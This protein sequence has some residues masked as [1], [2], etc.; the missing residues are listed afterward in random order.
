MRQKR[1]KQNRFL[2]NHKI[3]KPPLPLPYQAWAREQYPE[4]SAEE[5]SSLMAKEETK[6]AYADYFLAGE[7]TFLGDWSLGMIQKENGS[8]HPFSTPLPFHEAG[9]DSWYQYESFFSNRS[10]AE[11][12]LWEYLRGEKPSIWGREQM[13]VSSQPESNGVDFSKDYGAC[14][15]FTYTVPPSEAGWISPYIRP[16]EQTEIHKS[17]KIVILHNDKPIWPVGAVLSDSDTWMKGF[18]CKQSLYVSMEG[19]SLRVK[20]GD[21]IHFV[22]EGECKQRNLLDPVV[23]VHHRGAP[24]QLPSPQKDLVSRDGAAIP[25]MPDTLI[26]LWQYRVWIADEEVEGSLVGWM[27]DCKEIEAPVWRRYCRAPSKAGV[28]QL[29]ARW[30]DQVIPVRLA[31]CDQNGEYP[32]AVLPHRADAHWDI[33]EATAMRADIQALLGEGLSYWRD[34]LCMVAGEV[35]RHRRSSNDI[36]EFFFVSDTHHEINHQRSIPVANCLSDVLG[37]DRLIFGGD[38]M[39]GQDVLADSFAVRDAWLSL[40]DTFHGFWY[41]ARG[42]HDINTAFTPFSMDDFWTDADYHRYILQKSGV[43]SVQSGMRVVRSVCPGMQDKHGGAVTEPTE[44]CLF[45]YVDDEKARIRYYFLDDGCF[46]LLDEVGGRYDTSTHPRVNVIPYKEQLKWLQYTAT[47]G[48]D[49]LQSGWGL[50]VVEHRMFNPYPISDWTPGVSGCYKMLTEALHEILPRLTAE[51]VEIIAVLSG[52]THWDA[53]CQTP[54][55]YPVVAITCD[56]DYLGQ[57]QERYALERYAGSATEQAM[58]I[59]QIDRQ[60]RRLYFTRIGSGVNRSFSYKG[61][62]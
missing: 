4:S 53:D 16:S 51:G 43:Y 33:E 38:F 29:T 9:W 5:L 12:L 22:L 46:G 52:H 49:A 26:D 56:A 6:R 20:A 54:D 39:N 48:Q 36:S 15:S 28:Y 13:V 31:V 19:L 8:F 18:L 61:V 24:P 7:V 59:V 37:I 10:A 41:P 25:A 50:V 32:I 34:T 57:K 45:Y 60:N 35:M 21:R 58:D 3:T 47:A 2:D 44:D 17:M 14:F 1:V 11:E 40:M 27:N 42:N 55:G 62:D 30:K 23:L